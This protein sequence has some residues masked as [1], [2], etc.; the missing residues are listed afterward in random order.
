LVVAPV[1]VVTDNKTTNID[2]MVLRCEWCGV[3]QPPRTSGPWPYHCEH[4]M[5]FDQHN[6]ENR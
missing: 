1:G 5:R 2:E 4:P 3:K 6:D